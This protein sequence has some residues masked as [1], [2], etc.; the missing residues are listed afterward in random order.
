MSIVR[1]SLH[2][3]A[4]V[5]GATVM[6]AAAGCAP[7]RATSSQDTAEDDYPSESIHLIVQAAAGGGSDIT[8]R[9]LAKEMEKELGESVIV[10]NRTGAAGSTALKYVGDQ[11]A[12]GYTL[13][14]MP[15]EL[16]MYQHIGYDVN[17][18]DYDLLGQVVNIPGVVAVPSDSPYTSL[19]SLIEASKSE[20]INVANAGT[21]GVWDAATRGL[22]DASGAEFTRVPFDGDASAVGAA[23]GGQVDAVV[24]GAPAA[25][26]AYQEEN[27]RILAV[28]NSEPLTELPDVPTVQ[29]EGYDLDFG[30]WG[31][32]GTAENLPPEVKRV[33]EQAVQK[34]ASSEG[35]T[36]TI[37]KMNS[38]PV[39]RDSEEFTDFVT[40]Q[41]ESYE[42]TL[43]EEG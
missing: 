19:T 43:G 37:E 13:G 29:S 20:E 17:Y 23:M 28:Y 39:Y 30:G 31:G 34:A 2:A 15:V 10:E 8:A 24:A 5:A 36:E 32:I 12:D 42:E 22:A 6:T 4:I 18:E 40:S 9:A 3:L 25:I 14:Y 33:L 26:S 11:E 16:S 41:D 38:T 21:G 7:D 27:L 1:Q 35:Y